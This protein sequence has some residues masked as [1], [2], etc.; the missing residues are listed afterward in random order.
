MLVDR[1]KTEREGEGKEE[2]KR[3]AGGREVPW[4]WALGKEVTPASAAPLSPWRVGGPE[5]EEQ[6]GL[7]NNK[8]GSGNPGRRTVGPGAWKPRVGAPPPSTW[9]PWRSP[10]WAMGQGDWVGKA[11]P[12]P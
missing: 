8:G 3:E 6:V 11:T 10:N 12:C 5:H 9:K 4:H 2:R 7:S 1:R